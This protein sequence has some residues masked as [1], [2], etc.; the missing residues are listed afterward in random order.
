LGTSIKCRKCR[1]TTD[2]EAGSPPICSNCGAELDVTI[3]LQT[4]RISPRHSVL[5]VDDEPS[6]RA[7]AR[8]VLETGGFSVVAETSN[9]PDAALLAG[10]HQ[11]DFVV[12]DFR[13]PAMSG[14]HAAKLIRRVSPDTRIVV[15]SA[16]IEGDPPWAEAAVR[17]D[18]VDRLVDALSDAARRGPPGD[19]QP[20]R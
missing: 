2:L 17:K 18:E 15:F 7:V 11:P 1:A 5:I 6:A 3:D 9:G 12:L 13:M 16:V 14:E 20:R 4:G 19:E 10:E 8:A